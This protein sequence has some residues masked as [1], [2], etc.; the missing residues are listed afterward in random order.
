VIW[1][2]IDVRKSFE[3]SRLGTE[4]SWAISLSMASCTVTMSDTASSPALS[5]SMEV[6][7]LDGWRDGYLQMSGWRG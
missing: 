4:Y 3:Y 2:R 5:F 6:I 7:V 1:V